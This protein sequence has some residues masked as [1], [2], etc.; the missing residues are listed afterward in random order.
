MRKL[1][2]IVEIWKLKQKMNIKLCYFI[3]N[4]CVLSCRIFY[5]ASFNTSNNK[6]I[7][8]IGVGV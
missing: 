7:S 2:R 5:L 8:L 1:G 3:C 4:Y 6:F